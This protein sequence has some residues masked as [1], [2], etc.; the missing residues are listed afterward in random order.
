MNADEARKLTKEYGSE[1]AEEQRRM[2]R[3]AWVTSQVDDILVEIEI[4]A[5]RGDSTWT[6]KDTS[7]HLPEDVIKELKNLGFTIRKTVQSDGPA[8]A[9]YFTF[10][11]WK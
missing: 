10:V 1:S 3:K 4:V 8:P 5:R 2:A 11:E 7:R 6:P 9:F